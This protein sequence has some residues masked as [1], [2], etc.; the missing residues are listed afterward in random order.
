[1]AFPANGGLRICPVEGCLG[2]A[3]TRTDMRVHFLH[4]NVKD[5][6]VVLEEGNLPH[7][8]CP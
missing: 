6:V 3:A 7:P 5:T 1:M 8:R 2:Q 4:H